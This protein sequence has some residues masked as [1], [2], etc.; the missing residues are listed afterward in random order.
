MSTRSDP[1]SVSSV[2]QEVWQVVEAFNRAFASND[3]ERYFTFIADEITV[4]TPSNPYRIEGIAD[5]REEFEWGLRAGTGK[6]AYFQE[7]QPQVRVYGQVAVVTYYSRGAYGGE[8]SGK[9]L[10]LK[11]TDVLVKQKQGWKIV[12]I[13]VSACPS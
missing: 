10:Y 4:L 8:T 3:A 9:V 13:H 2:E 7:L 11:E 1:S 12:H 5:D 6:V